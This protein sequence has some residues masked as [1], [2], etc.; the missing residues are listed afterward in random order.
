MD[1]GALANI[2]STGNLQIS[3]PGT[4]TIQVNCDH[5]WL[6][7]NFMTGAGKIRQRDGSERVF[8]ALDQEEALPGCEQSELV[9]PMS[10]P[11]NN[12]VKVINGIGANE[13][14]GE[15]GWY[16]VE[17]LDAAYRSAAADGKLVRVQSLYE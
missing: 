1:N 12:L 15:I 2:G 4:L 3:D 17:L 14:P 13:S 6:D 9:Y 16:A 10:A 5:G 7:F 11:A 8:P